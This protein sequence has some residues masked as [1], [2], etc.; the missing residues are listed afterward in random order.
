MI[1]STGATANDP[2][3]RRYVDYR[4]APILPHR[5]NTS[6]RTEHHASRVNGEHVVPVIQHHIFD[7]RPALRARHSRVVYH[8]VQSA[9]S[10]CRNFDSG[11]PRRFVRNIQRLKQRIIAKFGGQRFPAA[12]VDIAYDYLRTLAYKDARRGFANPGRAACNYRNFACQSR[13]AHLITSRM[14]S[15]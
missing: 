9:P 11:I 15:T 6:A 1:G 12:D 13:S 2:E 5:C 14:E 7:H 10:G 4:T 3:D 8:D